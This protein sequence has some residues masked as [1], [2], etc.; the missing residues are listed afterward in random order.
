MVYNHKRK[1]TFVSSF[2]QLLLLIYIHFHKVQFVQKCSLK[3]YGNNLFWK[4]LQQ[5]EI[6]EFFL[7]MQ[8]KFRLWKNFT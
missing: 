6:E 5:N 3:T 7:K 8:M 1:E 4:E 2:H